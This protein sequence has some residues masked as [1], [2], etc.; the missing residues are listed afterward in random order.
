M[1]R[2]INDLI[3]STIRATDGDIGSVV[4]FYFDDEW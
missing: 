4:T 3:G 2:N 1:L